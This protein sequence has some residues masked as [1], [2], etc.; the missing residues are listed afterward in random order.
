MN[1]IIRVFPRRTSHTPNDD[2]VFIGEPPLERPEADEVH[3]SCTFTWD[4]PAAERL[5]LAWG[6]YYLVVKLGG[7]AY[8]DPGNGFVP[9]MYLR[10]GITTTHRGCNNKCPWCDAWRREGPWRALEIYPGYI[11]QDNN[12]FQGPR[13]HIDSV[14][15][16][17]QTQRHIQL[18]GG[19]DARCINQYH[20]DR[21]RGLRIEQLFLAC[22][23]EEAI[24]PLRKALKLLQMP[25]H[26]ARCYVLLKYNPDETILGAL[27]RLIQVWEAGAKPSAQLYQP[28]DRF[29]DYPPEWKRFQ[30]KWER[31]A[32]TWRHI[33][34]LIKEATG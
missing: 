20:A 26:K 5:K 17:L 22:D 24:K 2:L 18:T 7:P 32:A 31:P 28:K 21:I 33:E 23:T 1:K 19:V 4:K 9:G 16:M 34:A 3:I 8:D 12:L 29:I 14:I 13:S 27:A 11:I 25:R 10:E 6:Q 30:R 15:D